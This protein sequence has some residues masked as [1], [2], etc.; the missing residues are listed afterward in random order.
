[1]N[2]DEFYRILD[3][4]LPEWKEI[5][6]DPSFVRWLQAIA[7]DQGRTMQQLLIDAYEKNDIENTLKY[8]KA[9]TLLFR[10]KQKEPR[11]PINISTS[12]SGE[13]SLSTGLNYINL[14]ELK[15]TFKW[16]FQHGVVVVGSGPFRESEFVDFLESHRIEVVQLETD[17]NNLIIGKYEWE[18]SDIDRHIRVQNKRGKKIKIYSQ[19]MA[20]TYIQ[21][22]YDPFNDYEMLKR[23]KENHPALGYLSETG[24][25]WR[26]VK[27]LTRK[28]GWESDMPE[29][30]L[31]RI[32]GYRVGDFG[33]NSFERRKILSNIYESSFIDYFLNLFPNWGEP[34]TEER[35][36]KLANCLTSF[37]KYVKKK[38]RNVTYMSAISDWEDDLNWLKKRYY[39]KIAHKFI[40]PH[41]DL[42][43]RVH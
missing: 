25:L 35:L 36:L 12:T 28:S 22:D 37:I 32:V 15:Q 8:F 40:W 7:D 43:E 16:R 18:R 4:E 13:V 11:Q 27:K 17:T 10:G 24:F 1:M 14:P 42:S 29:M 23:F 41:P 39:N 3:T 20:M 19:E 9:F 33:V 5:N 2:K 6:T 26:D 21:F 31:L 38:Y 30:G 34:N